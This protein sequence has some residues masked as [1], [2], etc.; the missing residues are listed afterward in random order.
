VQRKIEKE[1]RKGG[2]VNTTL[3]GL[4]LDLEESIF[5]QQ[6]I[7]NANAVFKA[8]TH[9]YE[10]KF[11]EAKARLPQELRG[12]SIFRDLTAFVTPFALKLV[13][14]Q[15]Q[16]LKCEPTAI[17]SCTGTFTKTMG[18]PCAHKIQ[19]RW[20]DRA[21]GNILKLEDIHPHWRFTKPPQTRRA[22]AGQE[23]H[24]MGGDD[25][26]GVPGIQPPPPDDNGSH[27]DETLPDD[28]LRVQEPAV[29]KPKDRPR[30]LL[31][32]AWAAPSQS[33]R[34]RQQTLDRS[35]QRDPSAFKY[36]PD[37]PSSQVPDSQPST[38]RG[39]RDGASEV[40][41][42]VSEVCAGV[43]SAVDDEVQEQEVQER[44]R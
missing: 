37:L 39:G 29:V 2:K 7:W 43:V 33:Q 22:T 15:F 6:D 25:N 26:A 41:R 5:K 27:E 19:E 4:R 36:A 8:A 10:Q 23:D 42:V 21:G 32:K 35:T 40:D 24:A 34:R 17:V 14:A 28:I 38:Q 13:N 30:G 31:N 20:Y 3:K 9:N 44:R 16:R 18:L 11:E 12:V 1:W